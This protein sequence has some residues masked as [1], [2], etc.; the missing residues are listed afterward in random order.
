MSNKEIWYTLH[1]MWYEY[2]MV[3]EHLTSLQAAVEYSQHPVKMLV[4]LNHQ[5]YIETPT[6][7]NRVEV[8]NEIINKLDTIKHLFSEIIIVQKYD[9]E[10]FY[11]IGDWRR[12]IKNPNGYTCWGEADSLLPEQYFYVLSMLMEDS[13]YNVPHALSFSSRK[14]WDNSW[15]IVEHNDLAELP[16]LAHDDNVPPPLNWHDYITQDKLNSLN[17]NISPSVVKLSTCKFDGSLLS[18]YGD[19]PQLIPDDLHFAREDYCAQSICE[20]WNIPQFHVAN[21]LK[22]HNYKHPN[23]R[24]NTNSSRDDSAYKKYESESYQAM[25]QFIWKNIGKRG[26]KN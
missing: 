12:D 7:D 14:M 2:M 4:C 10:P 9:D 20:V 1:L 22:G 26:P 18:L 24:V 15:L 3:D 21:I 17:N 23:K 19:L 25:Q 11:N 8:F 6:E 16:T 13:D 5:T